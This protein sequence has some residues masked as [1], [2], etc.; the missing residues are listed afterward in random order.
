MPIVINEFEVVAELP[1]ARAEGET[2]A[3]DPTSREVSGQ[4]L[5]GIPTPHDIEVVVRHIKERLARVRAY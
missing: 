4:G 3:N 5:G 2:E 1:T